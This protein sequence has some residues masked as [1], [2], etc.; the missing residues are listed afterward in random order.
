MASKGFGSL[1][2]E[3]RDRAARAGSEYGLSRSQ[4]RGRYNRG[5]YNP[6]ARADP[7]VRVPREYR[8][9][10]EVINGKP[11]TDWQQAAYENYNKHVGPGSPKGETFKYNRYTVA[12]NA[13]HASEA[14]ARLMA[15]ASESELRAWASAQPDANGN[16]PPI[17]A[18]PGLPPGIK[19]GDLGYRD[20]GGSWINIFW[21]H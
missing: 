19:I 15:M 8:P 16:P 1:S 5:T 7:M 13:D 6:F 9:H 20:S 3:S 18:F 4:V 21:Y 2:K 10:T 11:V 17:E 12:E 14:I